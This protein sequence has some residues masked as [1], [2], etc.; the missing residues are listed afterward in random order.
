MILT[1]PGQKMTLDWEKVTLVWPE[2]E[3]S[4]LGARSEFAKVKVRSEGQGQH[5]YPP[6]ILCV[7]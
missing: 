7:R 1:L 6:L 4:D 3:N 2:T 5:P